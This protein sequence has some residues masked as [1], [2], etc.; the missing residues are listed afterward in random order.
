MPVIFSLSAWDPTT[1]ELRDWL[2]DR[3]LRDHPQPSRRSAGA[4]TLAAA[5]VD[6]DLILPVLDGFDEMAAH[7]RQVA[8]KALNETQH[9]WSSPAAWRSSPSP[10]ERRAHHWSGQPASS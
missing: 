1:V 9:P 6:A 8:L 2:I 4:S 5:L 10:S 7:L 3:L